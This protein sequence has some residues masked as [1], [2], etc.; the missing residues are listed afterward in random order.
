M[1]SGGKLAV[2]SNV[3][4]SANNAVWGGAVSLPFNTIFH[5]SIIEYFDR[6][7]ESWFDSLRQLTKPR[8]KG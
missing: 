8:R 3:T 5:P 1:N 6:R 7:F 2:H 4:L